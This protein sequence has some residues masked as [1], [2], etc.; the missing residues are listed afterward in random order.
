[1]EYNAKKNPLDFKQVARCYFAKGKAELY[2]FN[3]KVETPKKL[4]KW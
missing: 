4:F 1:M 2:L 3:D